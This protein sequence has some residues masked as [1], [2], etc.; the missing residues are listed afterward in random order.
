MKIAIL[1]AMRE[2]IEP[3][4]EHFGERGNT[5]WGTG[6]GLADMMETVNRARASIEINRQM[7]P[8]DVFTKGIFICFD[9]RNRVI[10]SKND[11]G[12]GKME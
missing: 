3:I 5:T 12:Q 11:E 2:E 8:Q 4:L 1:G 9:G 6:N 7:D 10:I